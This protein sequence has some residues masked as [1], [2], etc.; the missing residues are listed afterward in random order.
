MA[1]NFEEDT[2]GYWD[3]NGEY[4]YYDTSAQWYGDGGSAPASPT[5]AVESSPWELAY[6]EEN[7]PY[8]FNHATSEWQ[9]EVPQDYVDPYFA[10]DYGSP[11][12]EGYWDESGEYVYY[13]AGGANETTTHEGGGSDPLNDTTTTEDDPSNFTDSQ[14]WQAVDDGNGNVYYYN[15]FSGEQQWEEPASYTSERNATVQSV[16]P[17]DGDA[18]ADAAAGEYEGTDSEHAAAVHIQSIHRGKL[19]QQRV[20]DKRVLHQNLKQMHVSAVGGGGG[21][22]KVDSEAAIKVQSLL[23]RRKAVQ[24]SQDMRE[25]APMLKRLQDCVDD[26]QVLEG[27]TIHDISELFSLVRD[28]SLLFPILFDTFDL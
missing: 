5:N 28:F 14:G 7:N 24:R 10:G 25:L 2:T 11:T 20:A 15:N 9:Y 26:Q 27:V 3:D 8:Y 19:A 18:A 13:E 17:A 1:E 22:S 23:R 16:T 4:Q 6:D 12:H 21:G